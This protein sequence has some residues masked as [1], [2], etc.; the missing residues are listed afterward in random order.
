MPWL[1]SRTG[2]PIDLVEPTS[3][4]VDFADLAWSLAHTNRHAG[5]GDRQASVAAHILIGLPLATGPLRALWLLHGAEVARLGDVPEQAME[6]LSALAAGFGARHAA[7]FAWVWTEYRARH[8]KV[9]HAAAGVEM[10]TSAQL[11]ALQSIA[12][13]VEA[14]ERRDLH[15]PALRPE[16]RW[17][18][19]QPANRVARQRPAD[20]VADA[21]HEEWK[22]S[23]PALARPASPIAIPPSR[24]RR[25]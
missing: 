5:N 17:S 16:P 18:G 3:A 20:Q 10:P 4:Q 11:V 7:S 1:S 14:T 21:L 24:R 19:A 2:K 25:A 23:L 9:I 6:A 22:A 15:N 12:S 13:I 8:A